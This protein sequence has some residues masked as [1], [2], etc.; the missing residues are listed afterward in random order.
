[1]A[2]MK[3]GRDT[4]EGRVFCQECREDMKNYP[5]KPNVVVQL[6]QH[7]GT[8]PVK[9]AAVPRRRILS[10]AEVIR[11]LRRRCRTFVALWLVTLLLLLPATYFAAKYFFGESVKLPGQNYSTYTTVETE[12]P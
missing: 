1:L 9:R 11:R 5:V 3:C 8:A 6:P 2:C 4:L 7:K 12:E 10:N